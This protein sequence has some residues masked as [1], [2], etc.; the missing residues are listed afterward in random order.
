M[1]VSKE[2]ISAVHLVA[3]AIQSASVQLSDL[4]LASVGGG[5]GDPIFI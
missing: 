4:Q 1:E 3:T 2:E 5:C